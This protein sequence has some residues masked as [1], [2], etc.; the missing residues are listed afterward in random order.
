MRAWHPIPGS[1]GVME[2]NDNKWLL[3]PEREYDKE[4]GKMIRE[5]TRIECIDGPTNRGKKTQ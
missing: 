4:T 1:A 2:S 5:T 3:I